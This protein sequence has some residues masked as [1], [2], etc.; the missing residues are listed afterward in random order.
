VVYPRFSTDVSLP[1]ET[2]QEQRKT[3]IIYTQNRF[4]NDAITN[5]AYRLRLPSEVKTY[6]LKGVTKT[7]SF[8][9]PTDFENILSDLRSDTILYH[10][11][12]FPPAGIKAQR[13]LIEHNRSIYYSNLLTGAL[14]LHNLDSLALPFENYQLAYTPDLV[15]DIFV[16]K[17]DNDLLT[18]GKFTNSEG[19]NNW[20]IRSGTTQFIKDAEN[21][22]HAQNRF[23]APVSYTDSYGAVTKVKYFGSYFLFIEE[24]EDAL[25]NNAGVEIFNFRILAPQKIRDINENFSAVINDELGFV[26]AVA[27]LGKGNE[28]DDLTG[29][30][31]LTDVGEETIISNFFQ[32]PN[33]TQLAILGKSLLNH[34][35]TRYMYDFEAYLKTGNPTVVA[36]VSREKHFSADNNSPVQIGFEYSNGIGEVVMKKV[37]AE[38]GLAKQV[39]ANRDNSIIVDEIDTSSSNPKQLRW[40]GNGMTIKNNKG[41][42]VKQYEP[43]FSTSFQYEN[44]KELVETGVT[45]VM[46]FDAAGRLIKTE[47]PDG[48]FSKVVFDSWK[49]TVYDANDT[50]TESTWYLKRTDNSRA[51]FIT[52]IK[53]QQAA[54]KATKHSET[55]TVLHFDTL[56]RAVLSIEHNKNSVTNADE[57]FRTKIKLDTEGNLRSV[58]DA[59]EIAENGNKGNVVMQ[60]KYNMLGNQV[61]QNS[62]DAGQ[63]WLLTTIL[64]KPL[65]TWD[66]RNHEFRYFYDI[67]QRPTHGIVLGVDG[68][69]PLNHIFDRVFYGESLLTANR[70][71]EEALQTRNILGQVIQHYDTGGMV[72]IP[73]YDFKGK[74]IAT[75]QKLFRKYK[76]VANW[77][78]ANLLIDLEPGKGFTFTSET[79]ALGRITR[80]IS[81]DGSIITPSYNEA[82]LLDGETVFHPGA[83]LATTY[84][85][86]IDYNEKGQREKIV[87]G[88]G[89][90]AKFYYDKETFRLKRLET[91]RQNN[92]LLQDLYY[93]FDASGNITHIEDKA[94]PIDFFANAI[95]EPISEYTYDALYRLVEATGRENNA[96][97]A[98]G[99]CDNW[100]DKPFL[101]QMSQGGPMAVR[102]YT[103]R[104][105]YDA[106]GNIMEMK[107]LALG[108]NWTRNYNYETNSNRLKS[109][110]IGDNGNPANYVN[111]SHHPMHGYLVE[112]PHLENISWNFKEEVVSTTRQHCIDDNTPVITYYQYDGNGQR[113]RKITENQAAAGADPT[114]KEERIYIAGYELYKKHSGADAGLERVSL[115]LMDE[116]HRFVMVETRND[117]D[118][119]T[120]KQLVRYQLHNHLGSAALELDGTLEA[121]VISYE[122]YHPFGTTAYQ[123]KNSDIKSAAKRYRYTGMERDE[124]TGLEYHSARYYLPWLGRWLNADP[125]GIEDGVNMFAY[126]KNMPV[127]CSDQM[128]LSTNYDEMPE[129]ILNVQKLFSISDDASKGSSVGGIFDEFLNTIS[130]IGSAIGSAI[131]AVGEWIAETAVK[132]WHWITEAATAAWDWIKQ[133][134]TDVWNWIKGALATAWDWT[135]NAASTA[136]NWIKDAASSAWEWIKQA[137]AD[138]WNWFLAPVIR[139][140]TNAL[141][142]FAIG[143]LSGGLTGGIIGAATGAATGAIHGWAM[144][145]AHSYDWGSGSGWLGFL[146]DNTWGLP[147]SMVGSLF[148]TANILG[149]NPIDRTNSRD[150]NALMFENEWF[151]GYATTLG[152]VIVGTKGLA[153]DVVQHEL[154]HVL[155]AR[156]FGPVFYPS[157]LAH[158]AINTFLPFWLIYHNARYP[159][160]PIRNFGE[161]FSRG[162]YPHTWAEEWGYSVGGH[163]N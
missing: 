155:Q 143:F 92:Q 40:I 114:K 34:A 98:F 24:T 66:E 123:A 50:V 38:A 27:L 99:N 60:Y 2:R 83:A 70:G 153:H 68:I 17:V 150:S 20:W 18:E 124:E 1:I 122:E 76:E 36:T 161:Y 11:I 87:Y 31:E 52:D 19:D 126:C 26:K 127:T 16:D 131:V 84:I 115:S 141:G 74:P 91:K 138:V 130:E 113:I 13:R 67:L 121:K 69:T 107:H 23:Y 6:E 59:R 57:F 101:N 154:A 140:A 12:D 39:I 25:G 96:A 148:A 43:Y 151:S 15:V 77:I 3:V 112:L 79:D 157:M 53:E 14:P 82:A 80:Q 9:S 10:D 134:A 56:G 72:D 104:Y 108:G 86:N 64:G 45:P 55:P 160:T 132:A 8:Y 46:Y 109:T 116:G 137:A 128:G 65:R 81:P 78:D 144:A 90:I 49:Q 88:N 120:E 62:M 61:Y 54:A 28:A 133:A 75:T 129:Q 73:N 4:T 47:M 119:G 7:G 44:L 94:I 136:W 135:K 163:P 97:L 58:T 111:Y 5:D 142:G 102:N 21:Q 42:A 93:T 110:L 51:D 29:I 139:T 156:I 158:Y 159:N 48:T 105:Q 32:S 22:T 146:A 85:K 106:V 103:Q 95:I 37:Q 41:N 35:T 147:N 100:S 149:G 30:T 118:D 162:V 89:V 33:S 145:D 117:V 152:N 63:R 71:N 125:I